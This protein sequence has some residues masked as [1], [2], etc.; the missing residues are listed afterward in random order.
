[1]GGACGAPRGT[2]ACTEREARLKVMSKNTIP[3][4]PVKHVDFHQLFKVLYGLGVI[5]GWAA[6]GVMWGRAK[7]GVHK[8][9]ASGHS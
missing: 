7:N 8:N 3:G 5:M 4:N 9:Q 2:F 6:F 1:M